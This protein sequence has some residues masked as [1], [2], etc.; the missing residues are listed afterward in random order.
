MLKV[1]LPCKK[2]ATVGHFVHCKSLK[3]QGLHTYVGMLSY[4]LK[5]S[6]EFHFQFIERNVIVEGKNVE[7]MEHIKYGVVTLRNRV[8]LWQTN[9]IERTYT[10]AKYKM[11]KHLGSLFLAMLLDMCRLNQLFL[12]TSCGLSHYNQVAWTTI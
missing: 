1:T 6:C 7:K 10:W 12:T 2:D 3:Q 8:P 4:C 9:V 11:H 5:D